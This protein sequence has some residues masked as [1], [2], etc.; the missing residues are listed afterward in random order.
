MVVQ[1][2]DTSTLEEKIGDL[3]KFKDSL[4]YTVSSKTART[5][6]PCLQKKKKKERQ[7]DRQGGILK[8]LTIVLDIVLYWF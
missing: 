8:S 3:C 7:T 4:V 1:A 2:F 5:E 6:K